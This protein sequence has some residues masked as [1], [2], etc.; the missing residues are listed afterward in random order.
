MT[1]GAGIGLLKQRIEAIPTSVRGILLALIAALSFTSLHTAIRYTSQELH[2]FEITFFRYLLSVPIILPL[3]LRSR[4][5]VLKTNCFHL[6]ALRC[7][8][9]LCSV[10]GLFTALSLSPLSQ[11]TSLTFLAPVLGAAFAILFLQE[12]AGF[13]RWAAVIGGFIGTLVVLRPG[14]IEIELGP[15]LAIFGATMWALSILII[16]VMSKT[17]SSTTQVTYLTLLVTPVSMV[18]A[19]FFWQWPNL[20]QWLLLFFIAGVATL[21]QFTYTQS[22]TLADTTVL[23]PLDFTRM[24]WATLFG[25]AFFGEL[26]DLWTWIGGA[27]IFASAAMVTITE[28]RR[29]PP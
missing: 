26:P 7:F 25:Y 20:E 17:E 8:F 21:G 27:L 24:V 14:L 18:A 1:S 15:I 19:L 11:V 16:K 4:F 9:L 5:T 12:Y 28:A 23:M 6:H 3:L 13:F 2:V 29:K 22:F 10:A